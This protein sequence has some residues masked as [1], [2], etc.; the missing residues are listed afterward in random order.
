MANLQS[1]NRLTQFPP[2]PRVAL[3]WNCSCPAG[4]QVI[5]DSGVIQID[6]DYFNYSMV[7][8]GTRWL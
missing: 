6:Q 2:P 7:A 5:N 4:F 8:K 3:T 1:R